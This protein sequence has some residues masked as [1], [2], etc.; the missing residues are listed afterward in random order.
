MNNYKKKCDCN[1]N[2][3]AIKGTCSNCSRIKIQV[4]FKNSFKQLNFSWYC[5]VAKNRQPFNKTA[6]KMFNKMIQNSRFKE[7][8]DKINVVIAYDNFEN[9][10][11]KLK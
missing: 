6:E 11:L 8:E 10:Q 9:T 7:N 1:N 2:T 5:M 4:Y 3:S